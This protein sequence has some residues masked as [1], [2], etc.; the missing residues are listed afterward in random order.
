M[1]LYQHLTKILEWYLE[2]PIEK[3]WH[4]PKELQLPII[5]N[6][7]KPNLFRHYNL[8]VLLDLRKDNSKLQLWK[9]LQA[10]HRIKAQIL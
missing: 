10:R 1:S 4:K 5:I 2:V 7:K 8:N 9:K 3:I 6:Q